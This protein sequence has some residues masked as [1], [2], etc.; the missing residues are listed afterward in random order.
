MSNKKQTA[1][2]FLV[3]KINK[4][5]SHFSLTFT[6]EIKQAKEMEKQQIID[7]WDNG[8]ET[9]Y[10]YISSKFDNAEQYYTETYKNKL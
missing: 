5:N 7:S 6:E 4:F 8:Y 9:G 10:G 1:V 2:E 3:E